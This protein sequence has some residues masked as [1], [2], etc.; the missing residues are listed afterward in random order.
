MFEE[1]QMAVG[2]EY[3]SRLADSVFGTRDRAQAEGDE[4]RVE[5]GIGE[6]KRFRIGLQQTDGTGGVCRAAAAPA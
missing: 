6:R 5:L 2:F 4:N 1:E 3:A